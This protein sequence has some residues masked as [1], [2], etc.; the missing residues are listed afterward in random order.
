MIVEPDVSLYDLSAW[1]SRH[2]TSEIYKVDYDKLRT[3]THPHE[4]ENE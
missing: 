3:H 2:L 4:E 1:F